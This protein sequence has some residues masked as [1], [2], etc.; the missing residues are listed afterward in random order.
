MENLPEM[1]PNGAGR[2]FFPTNLDLANMLGD[3]DFDFD[4]FYL[5]ACFLDFKFSRFLNS[6]AGPHPFCCN[7]SSAIGM[8]WL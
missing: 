7:I 3:T 8:L 4:N 1:P 2:C 6:R 5:W